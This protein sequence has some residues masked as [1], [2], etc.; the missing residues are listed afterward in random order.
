L[1]HLPMPSTRLAEAAGKRILDLFV[2]RV[3]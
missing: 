1:A 2:R 3:L